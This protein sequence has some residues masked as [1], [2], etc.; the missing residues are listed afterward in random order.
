LST[1]S[2]KNERT[3]NC[4]NC[5]NQGQTRNADTLDKTEDSH[6]KSYHQLKIKN[7][8]ALLTKR[9]VKRITKYM[10]DLVLY[11]VQ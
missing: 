3:L 10:E 11:Y 7:E 9:K 1:V 2:E 8:A 4:S 5:I 6:M